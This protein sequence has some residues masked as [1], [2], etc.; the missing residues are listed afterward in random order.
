MTKSHS[1]RIGSPITLLLLSALLLSGCEAGAKSGKDEDKATPDTLAIRLYEYVDPFI[2]T[3]AHGHTFPGATTPLGLVQL[4]PD[5]RWEG[6]DAC[7]GYHYSDSRLYGFSHTHLSGT[8]AADLCDLLF[9]PARDTKLYR[10]SLRG[11]HLPTVP[12]SHDDEEAHAGYYAVTLGNGIRAELTATP[13]AGIH[14]YTFPE[15][16]DRHLIIDLVSFKEEQMD[17]AAIEKVGNNAVQG[18]Q[19]TS[20]WTKGEEIYFYAKFS[21]PIDSIAAFL[22]GKVQ[23]GG[24]AEGDS[25]RAFLSFSRSEIPLEVYVGLSTTSIEGAKA[26]LEQDLQGRSFDDLRAAAEASWEKVLGK[27]QIPRAR[28]DDLVTFYTALYHAYIAPNLI[29]DASGS[30]RGLD[31][32]VHAVPEGERQY[33]TFSLWDTYRSLHPWYTLFERETAADF[34]R[35]LLNMYDEQ[36]ELPIWPLVSGETRTMIGFHAA[37]VIADAYLRGIGGFSADRALEAMVK[38]SDINQKGGELYARYGYVP[39]DRKSEDVS[40]T[41][42]YTYDD[43]AISMMADKMGEAEIANKYRERALGYEKLFDG[44]TGFFRPK[45]SDGGWMDYFDPYEVSS[46]YTEANAF[47]YRFAAQHDVNGMIQ[48]YGGREPFLK[49]L[50]ELYA[51]T[52]TLDT[53]LP[54]LTG[55]IGQYIHGN[56]P[57]HHLAYLFTYA[58]DAWKTQELTRQIISELYT[59]EPDGIPGNEDCGQMS[60]WYLFSALGFYPVTPGSG[61]YLLTTPLFSEAS[62]TLSN[63]KVLKITAND[64]EDNHYIKGVSLNGKPLS[65]LFITYDEIMAGGTLAFDLTGEPVTDYAVTEQPYSLTPGEKASPVYTET[66]LRLFEKEAALELKTLTPE[67]KIRY[68]LDGSIPTE[69]SPLYERPVTINKDATIQAVAF[70]KGSPSSPAVFHA[71]KARYL[72]PAPEKKGLKEGLAYALYSGFFDSVSE[73]DKGTLREKGTALTLS[74]DFGQKEEG[75]GIIFNGYLRVDSDGVYELALTSDDGSMLYLDGQET[76]LNDG[77][78]SPVTATGFVALRKGLHR[79]EVR[80]FQGYAGRELSFR[81]RQRGEKEFTAPLLFH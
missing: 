27:V 50:H 45:S 57:S 74:D 11:K 32:E 73:I 66:N 72:P 34:V 5:T 16:S 2:G 31:G 48:L 77:S 3:D 46:H 70:G 23:E 10:D 65:R 54:D 25:V 55:I 80:Y 42:E 39:F 4:S 44:S 41:L 75:Y 1:S 67:S 37:S 52:T 68:T 51:D 43:W 49:V 6:W 12:F 18:F 35:S 15:G 63:G 26:N 78:H 17:G 30:Y 22:D 36:G 53:D 76:V 58:G 7:S 69:K 14:R 8:G 81:I 59:S 24:K 21:L 62:L 64:P 19:K 29:S 71:T 38:S 79:L 9:I 47:Q 33:S 20:A 56:E 60:A 13:Y 61:E 28:Y 40:Q